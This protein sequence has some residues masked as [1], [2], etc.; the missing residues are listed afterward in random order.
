MSDST[1]SVAEYVRE[2]EFRGDGGDYTPTEG[3][4]LLIEDALHGFLADHEAGLQPIST[5]AMTLVQELVSGLAPDQGEA[6]GWAWSAAVRLQQA[7]QGDL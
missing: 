4:R 6:P 2:Y 1:D 3:E 5:N 7:L